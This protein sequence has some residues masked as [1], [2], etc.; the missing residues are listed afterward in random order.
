MLA[1][2]FWRLLCHCLRYSEHSGRMKMGV[3]MWGKDDHKYQEQTLFNNR[4]CRNLGLE[5]SQNE[6]GPVENKIQHIKNT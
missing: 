2:T 6:D 3:C 4:N 5:V 1:L